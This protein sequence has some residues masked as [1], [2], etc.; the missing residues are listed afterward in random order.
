MGKFTNLVLVAAAAALIV[1]GVAAQIGTLKLGSPGHPARPAGGAVAG[2]HAVA[3][4]S[5]PA[6]PT[7]PAYI[8][9]PS[10]TPDTA[11]WQPP[12][13]GGGGG[14]NGGGGGGGDGD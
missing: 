4:P 10:P 5:I 1:I 9:T 3:T 12:P 7:Q 14:G 11:T 2:Q 13:G 6:S 8:V